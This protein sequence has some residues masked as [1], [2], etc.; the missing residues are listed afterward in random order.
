M[1][2]GASLACLYPMEPEK[3]LIELSSAG[4]DVCEIFLNT[5]S[6]L[7]PEYLHD[8]RAL[9]DR[10]G[11]EVYSIHPF[12]SALEHYMF[13]SPYPRRIK[14]SFEFYS[15]YADA[16]KILGAK[17]INIH[18]DRG[19]KKEGIS[20][21]IECISPFRM[22]QDKTGVTFAMEN[23]FY[24]S[25]NDPEFVAD[26]I[27]AVPDLC[28]TF[29]IKQACKGG[30]DPYIL[31][32]AM[33]DRVVNFHVNDC[34]FDHVCALP[35]EGDIDYKRIFSILK[36]QKYR[37]PALIEVYRNNFDSVQDIIKS[38]K[39]LESEFYT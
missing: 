28:F 8:L 14:D 30:Q 11:M 37:G 23:V 34:D 26:L 2:F 21:Y 17:V 27:S 22:V 10:F 36:H 20:F 3:A 39:F 25:V 6:E 38:K 7:S 29:D 24:N 18:G 9:C 19:V 5:Y 32:Q 4:I 13:F 1:K 12:T 15:K 33:Q 35:G 16:A 31:L